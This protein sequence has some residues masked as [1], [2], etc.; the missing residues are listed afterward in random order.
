MK[1][2]RMLSSRPPYRPSRRGRLLAWVGLLFA[3]LILSNVTLALAQEGS[4]GW[5]FPVDITQQPKVSWR[6]FPQILCDPY[7][8]VHIFWGDNSADQKA[9]YYRTDAS[10]NWSIPVDVLLSEPFV[11]FLSGDISAKTNTIHLAWANA[12][13]KA[14]LM[15]S[16]AELGSAT[17]PRAWSLPQALDDNIFNPTINV[18]SQ[19]VVHIIYAASDTDELN[20]DVLHIQSSDNGRTWTTPQVIFYTTFS[21]ASYI[22]IESAI[23]GADR[24][25]VGLTLRSVTYGSFSEVGYIRSPDGGQTWD[26]YR[27]IDNTSQSFQ[28]VEWIAPYTFG[29]DE[30]HL[31]WH[32]PRRLHMWSTDGGKSWTGPDTIMQLGAAF[33]GANALAKDAAGNLFAITAWSDGVFVTPRVGTEWGESEQIDNRVIDPHGQVITACQGNRLNVAYYD[34]TGDATIWFSSREV[35][36]PHSERQ[37]LPQST[38]QEVA[39]SEAAL[40]QAAGGEPASAATQ[41]G[42]E[43][44]PEEWSTTSQLPGTSQPLVWGLIPAAIVIVGV[45]V[46]S[47]RR[48]R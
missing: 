9:I 37:P 40:T 8:N 24:I 7:Q 17:S 43:P 22:R 28:G 3:G 13:G 23:D 11:Y 15:Y 1:T 38:S 14:D 20:F 35:A 27:R 46:I 29:Q 2:R 19:G 4:I 26:D 6:G 30:V 32:D 16:R 31:T 44:L 45:I 42:A 12:Q 41:V 39:S 21:Q 36:A 48:F 18:D 33:G 25:H 10:G 47:I 5:S 34:R